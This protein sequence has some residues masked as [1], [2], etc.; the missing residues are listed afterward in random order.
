MDALSI[1]VQAQHV[2]ARRVFRPSCADRDVE[3]SKEK[4]YVRRN[5]AVVRNFATCWN[6]A[7]AWRAATEAGK[8][9]TLMRAA[10]AGKS[11]E[12]KQMLKDPGLLTPSHTFSTFSHLLTPSHTFHH[13]WHR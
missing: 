6:V 3:E 4:E 8:I 10:R 2:E 7:E 9:T 13:V 5:P 1:A 11:S 12:V